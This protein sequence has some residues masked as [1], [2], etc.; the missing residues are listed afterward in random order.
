M[1]LLEDVIHYYVCRSYIT[2]HGPLCNAE[3]IISVDDANNQY[4]EFQQTMRVLG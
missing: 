2:R 4:N 1:N 3:P